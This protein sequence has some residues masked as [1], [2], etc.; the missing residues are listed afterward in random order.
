MARNRIIYQSQAL[1]IAPN[2]NQFHLQ[3]GGADSND[4]HGINLGSGEGWTGVTGVNVGAAKLRSLVTPLERIQSANFNFSINRTDIN[5]FGKLARIDSIAMESPTVG[6]DFNYYLTDGGN[7]RKLGFNIPT[8]NYG[9]GAR[10]NG[11]FTGDLAVSGYSALSG[12]ID[13]NEGNNYFIV[14]SPEGQDVDQS[15]VNTSDFEVIGIGNGFIS[16]YSIEA[17]V[18]SIPTASVTV[19]GFNIK[20]DSAISGSAVGGATPQ[21]PYVPAVDITNGEYNTGASAVNQFVIQGANALSDN[22][23]DTT[24]DNGTPSALRPGDITF[25]MLKSGDYQGFVDMDGD[26]EAHLQSMS[27]SV[28]MS[29]TVLQ[30]LGSTF[31]YARV[32]DLPLNV[33]VSL[34]VVVSEL[35]ANNIFHALCNVQHHDF[36]LTLYGC[37]PATGGRSSDKKI[38]IQCK[39]ARLEGE[40]FSNTIGDNQTADLTFS[41]QIGGSNDKT[42]GVIM[43]GSYQLFRTLPFFPLGKK[44]SETA[45]YNAG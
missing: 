22:A 40:S 32:I 37:D 3:S 5:E 20:V 36:T 33:D 42:S 27:I 12:L 9:G 24:G 21:A 39:N 23:I 13:D 25:S 14:V 30:R 29:R 4:A 18:G 17:A 45:S 15:E 8:S 19:E 6:L 28:P 31:G 41:C 35:K 44:K 11:Y 43:D 16:D 38:Q 7:E 2:S 1:F 34:S 10:T 26:G